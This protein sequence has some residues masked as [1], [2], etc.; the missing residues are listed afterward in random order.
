LVPIFIKLKY[1]DDEIDAAIKEH[2]TKIDY[3]YYNIG[4]SYYDLN[5][6]DLS[7]KYYAKA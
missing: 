4:K 3:I 2:D 7:L 5:H 6:N 1:T